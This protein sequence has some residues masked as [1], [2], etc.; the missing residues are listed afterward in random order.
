MRP[1]AQPMRS[2]GGTKLL[3][4]STAPARGPI[5]RRHRP[6]R[7]RYRTYRPC[8]R[9]EFGFT[10]AFC[11]VSEA[12]LREH[13]VE[14]TG[15]TG[16]EH[17]RLQSRAPRLRDAYENCYYACCWCNTA[18]SD[19]PNHDRAGRTLLEPCQSSWADHFTLDTS[20][21][22]VR[23][24]PLA[25]DADADY[26]H[27]TYDM[28]DPRKRAVRRSRARAVDE[29]LRTLR[30]CAALRTQLSAVAGRV[31]LDAAQVVASAAIELRRQERN[32]LY[33]LERFRAVPTDCD[34]AC[35]CSTSKHCSLPRF[36]VAQC[37]DPP[38][39][40]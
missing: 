32:A 7:G 9:W 8:L 22:D 6:R 17:L 24:R 30:D 10:C 5:R 38:G 40:A 12:D 26:T 23:L 37:A 18:R 35:R 34:D 28:D 21:G 13:G 1:F 16:I 4:R 11:L 14:G 33:Q 36:L 2:S 39:I 20:E 29:A 3:P 15:L 27:E 19:A 31:D 25:G